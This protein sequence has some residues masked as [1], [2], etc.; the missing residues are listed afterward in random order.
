MSSLSKYFSYNEILEL[1]HK[2]LRDNAPK[3]VIF[4]GLVCFVCYDER[5]TMTSQKPL[6]CGIYFITKRKGKG[7]RTVMYI[8]GSRSFGIRLSTH[9]K[10]PDIRKC[11]L[12]WEHIE[13][14]CYNTDMYK[15]QE[16]DFIIKYAPPFNVAHNPQKKHSIPKT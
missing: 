16:K 1:R 9:E 3:S 5:G 4:D 7:K 13:I 12:E 6:G 14:L 2:F 11:L 15:T 8:G 10:M